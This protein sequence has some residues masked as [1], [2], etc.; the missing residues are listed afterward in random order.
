MS[1]D[2]NRWG[3]IPR[4]VKPITLN[5]LHVPTMT[6]GTR[7]IGQA[8]EEWER[9]VN[10]DL[11]SLWL[12]IE[13]KTTSMFI[14]VRFP[15]WS[16]PIEFGHGSD[17]QVGICFT[18]SGNPSFSIKGFAIRCLHN[19]VESVMNIK[20]ECLYLVALRLI[21]SISVISWRWYDVWKE[22]EKTRLYTFTD[23]RDI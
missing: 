2:W 9:A 3:S 19:K 10:Y 13:G 1:L 20:H 7:T 14:L 15:L 6:F 21:Y 5:F 22:K 12:I 4:W 11:N 16:F 23:S 8:A 18:K 17:G